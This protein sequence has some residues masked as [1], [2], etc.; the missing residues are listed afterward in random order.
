VACELALNIRTAIITGAAKQAKGAI[1][2]A[3]GKTLGDARLIA[4]GKDDKVEGKTRPESHRRPEGC[5]EEVAALARIAS[6][7][8]H[9]QCTRSID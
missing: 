2:E 5:A 1:K 4:N 7:S 9:F 6:G 3:A 8:G